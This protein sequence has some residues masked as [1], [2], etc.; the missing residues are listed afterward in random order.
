M[1]FLGKDQDK[2]IIL[3]LQDVIRKLFKK[4]SEI[5]KNTDSGP[6]FNVNNFDRYEV[7]CT[8]IAWCLHVSSTGSDG[9]IYYYTIQELIDQIYILLKPHKSVIINGDEFDLEGIHVLTKAI[10]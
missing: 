7:V 1:S 6:Y 10:R 3:E 8:D 5:D 4:H 2:E 9:Y